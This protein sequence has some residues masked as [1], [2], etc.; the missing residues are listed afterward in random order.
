MS[1]IELF[2]ENGTHICYDATLLPTLE[3]EIF[4]VDW[5]H[6]SGVWQGSSRG[7][8]Q[9]HFFGYAGYD[10]VLRHF[11]RGGLI[12]RVNNDA[13]LRVGA[14]NSRAFREFG[15]LGVM[16]SRGLFVPR[17]VAARYVPNGLFYRADIITERIPNARTLEEVLQDSVLAPDLWRAT[18]AA[19]RKLHDHK[20]FHSDLNC[21]N[22]MIDVD[23]TVWLI[24]FDKCAQREGDS[25]K[26]GNLD[27]LERSLHKVTAE[28]SHPNWGRAEWD[29][30]RAGYAAGDTA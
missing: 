26:Q 7:R 5:L 4:D 22:I 2:S 21:R 3:P 13:F 29:M 1:R 28:F 30:L 18:G 10:L 11:H 24:D 23:S 6:T 15:L 8:N 25:W 20:V 19:I 27:R 12:G 9:A 17:P 14:Q 16:R